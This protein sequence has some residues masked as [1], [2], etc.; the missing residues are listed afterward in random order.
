MPDRSHYAAFIELFLPAV[1]W[2]FLKSPKRNVHAGV[3]TGLALASII[4]SASAAG[5]VVA[6]VEILAVFWLSHYWDAQ[7]RERVEMVRFREMT[8]HRYGKRREIDVPGIVKAAAQ[9]TAGFLSGRTGDAFWL[10]GRAAAVL[11]IIATVIGIA[12]LQQRL[13]NSRLG[14]LL[15]DKRQPQLA[16]TR[17]SLQMF[18]A[19]P[20]LGSGLDTWPEVYPAY[21]SYSTGQRPTSHAYDEPVEWLAEGG[22]LFIV[23]LAL[24]AAACL[25][26]GV[27]HPWAL[28]PTGVLIYSLVSDPFREPAIFA[29]LFLI[30]ATTPAAPS[31]RL[32]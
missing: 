22:V 15:V 9:S 12:P 19:R 31:R 32:Q 5:W 2:Y 13:L 7:E 6:V 29:C 8:Y 17:T 16:A 20:L 23:P 28:G 25:R 18:G 30:L 3:A 27:D 21:H 10:R 14:T 26:S 11:L 4:A 24:L 1:F